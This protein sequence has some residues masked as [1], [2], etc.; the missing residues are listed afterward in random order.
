MVPPALAAPVP[1]TVHIATEAAVKPQSRLTSGRETFKG[2][3]AWVKR[4]PGK[5]Q[6]SWCFRNGG[7]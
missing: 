7:D 2:Y 4:S 6:A 3:L 1:A 5:S